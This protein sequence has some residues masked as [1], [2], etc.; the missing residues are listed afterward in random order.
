MDNTPNNIATSLEHEFL[1]DMKDVGRF[2]CTIGAKG[3]GKS[4]TMLAYLKF[5]I[6]NNLYEKYHLVLPMFHLE[7][8]DS[9]GFLK[10]QKHCLIYESFHPKITQR[11]LADRVKFKVLFI[12]D[13]STSE[14]TDNIDKN[15]IKLLTTTRHGNKGVTIWLIFHASK[16][17]MS[18]AIRMQIDWLLLT[19][20]QNMKLLE[21]IYEEFLGRYFDR[22]R[23]FKQF[24]DQAMSEK[25]NSIIF[26][27]QQKGIDTNV[28]NWELLNSDYDLQ[29]TKGAPKPKPKESAVV[30]N[31]Q[32]GTFKSMKFS[33][34]TGLSIF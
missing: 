9:Y 30:S 19:N 32:A 17:V 14:L 12:I 11:V 25:Y 23:D 20:M 8:N 21:D 24:Y 31:R 13:D 22:F 3:G 4:Y 28:K 33:K 26:G 27:T 18:P 6:Q 7:A 1:D 16:K 2:V 15:F 34:R 10:D 5:A 29:P